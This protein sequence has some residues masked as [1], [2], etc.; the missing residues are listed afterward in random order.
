MFEAIEK[1]A[2]FVSGLVFVVACEMLLYGFCT[3]FEILELW[4]CIGCM[5][6]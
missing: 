2:C 3:P 1:G 4:L 6:I 5:S